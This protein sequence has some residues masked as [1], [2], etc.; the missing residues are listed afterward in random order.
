MSRIHEKYLFLKAQFLK[1]VAK[2][3]CPNENNS[4]MCKRKNLPH[5]LGIIWLYF[6]QMSAIKERENYRISTTDQTIWKFY[7]FRY[8]F[9]LTLF[10]VSEQQKSSLK[11]KFNTSL[12]HRKFPRNDHQKSAYAAV[13][14]HKQLPMHP[15]SL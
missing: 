3:I 5:C 6:P 1:T 9:Y 11:K 15:R 12:K 14:S 4:N 13:L 8:L 10:F 2:I 7:I